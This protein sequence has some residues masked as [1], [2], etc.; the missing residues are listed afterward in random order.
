[1]ACAVCTDRHDFSI[2]DAW[3]LSAE[4]A[5]RPEPFG[6]LAYHFGTRQLTFLR[7]RK[8]LGLV[9][10]LSQYATAQEACAAAGV[11]EDELPVYA[12]SLEQLAHKGMIV[13]RVK[14]DAK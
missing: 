12:R 3:R 1:M 14:N 2:G 8:L 9:E 11:E 7:S 6:A 4:V 5:I 13:R 10:S